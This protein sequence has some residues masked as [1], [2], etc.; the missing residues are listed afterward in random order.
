MTENQQFIYHTVVILFLMTSMTYLT[1]NIV[2]YHLKQIGLILTLE[3]NKGINRLITSV[4]T[5]FTGYFSLL[6]Y[7]LLR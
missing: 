6:Y 4:V 5:L 7:L 3:Q 1:Q 2:N